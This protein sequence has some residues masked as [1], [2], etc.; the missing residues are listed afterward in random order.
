M[1]DE[2]KKVG[3]QGERTDSRED[4]VRT[5]PV[6]PVSSVDG[7]YPGY[8][9]NECQNTQENPETKSLRVGSSVWDRIWFPT[10]GPV[11]QLRPF[12]VCQS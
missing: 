4:T 7:R 2:L 11:L 5:G 1:R 10:P 6:T 12:T 9:S 8:E 3:D